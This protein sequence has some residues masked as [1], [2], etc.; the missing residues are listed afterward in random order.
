MALGS[1]VL[2]SGINCLQAGYCVLLVMR[3]AQRP[4]TAP[5]SG[6]Q[7]RR[8]S[9]VC[10]GL[11][12]HCRTSRRARPQPTPSPRCCSLTALLDTYRELH[13]RVLPRRPLITAGHPVR[14]PV[15]SPSC[16]RSGFA[17]PPPHRPANYTCLYCSARQFMSARPCCLSGLRENHNH[18]T[19][20]MSTPT[21]TDFHAFDSQVVGLEQR[22]TQE[23]GCPR[24]V[25][26]QRRGTKLGSQ[27]RTTIHRPGDL[28]NTMSVNVATSALRHPSTAHVKPPGVSSE[29]S[30]I[31]S[32]PLTWRHHQHRPAATCRVGDVT[33][34]PDVARTRS[35]SRRAI[36]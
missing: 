29:V 8:P 26:G 33:V 12:P 20:M 18:A 24:L 21:N 1:S 10:P 19:A 22:E 7:P 2:P 17:T 30:C 4:V 3:T 31:R 25:T 14:S 27:D 28:L 36:R 5:L 13:L 34:G 11:E 9:C 23:Q 15:P 16:N 35:A 32:Q 6:S